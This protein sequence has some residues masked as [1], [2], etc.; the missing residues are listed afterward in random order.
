MCEPWADPVWN[1]ET[2]LRHAKAS[3][4]MWGMSLARMNTV[5]K[6][7]KSLYNPFVHWTEVR[8]FEMGCVPDANGVIEHGVFIAETGHVR[9]YYFDTEDEIGYSNGELTTYIF[10]MWHCTGEVHGY[11]I[12]L[13]ELRRDKL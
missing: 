13:S 12:T 6:G 10:V 1:R 2:Y 5:A 11:P 7:S 4:R 3:Q 9:T 8:D